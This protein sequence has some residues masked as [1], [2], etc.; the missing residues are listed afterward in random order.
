MYLLEFKDSHGFSGSKRAMWQGDQEEV[1]WYGNVV[2]GFADGKGVGILIKR[3]DRLCTSYEGEFEKGFSVSKATVKRLK[4]DAGRKDWVEMDKK[5]LTTVEFEAPTIKF[6]YES[7]S[8][9]GDKMKPVLN[10]CIAKMYKKDIARLDMICKNLQS[11][12]TSNYKEMREDN[13]VK[14][15]SKYYMFTDYDPQHCLPKAQEI[16]DAFIILRGMKLDIDREYTSSMT[17]YES[18]DGDKEFLD[19][20][21]SKLN[22]WQSNGKCGLGKFYIVAHSIL[23]PKMKEMIQRI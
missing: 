9:A 6:Y 10:Q 20:V 3:W 15:F 5:S 18:L 8:Y 7:T 1:L 14:D 2:D 17:H 19:N 12:T 13:F 11:V 23:D 4:L 21:M 22:K 16:S